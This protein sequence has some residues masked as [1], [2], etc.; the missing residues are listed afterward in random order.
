MKRFLLTGAVVLALVAAGGTAYKAAADTEQA[1]PN[2]GPPAMGPPGMGP[3]G[4]AQPPGP[5]GGP[6]GRCGGPGRWG[7]AAWGGPGPWAHRAQMFSL[8]APVKNKNLSDSDVKIIAIAFLLIHGNHDWSVAN[9]VNEAD[10]SI[11][12]S[13][14]TAHGDVIAT[15]AI[16]PVSGRV[17]RIS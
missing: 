14:V 10:K 7:Q 2:A 13:Y 6:P 8:F 4:M 15:F 12:F 17:H 1:A 11:E 3:P 9:V 5:P 16:D